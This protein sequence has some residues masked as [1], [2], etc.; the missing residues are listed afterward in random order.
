M[1]GGKRYGQG[2]Y[3]AVY[4]DPRIPCKNEEYIRDKIGEKHEVSKVMFDKNQIKQLKNT[5]NI[6]N[7]RFKDRTEL[8]KYI[9]IPSR[10]C[11]VNHAELKRNPEV[12]TAKWREYDDISKYKLQTVS[13]KGNHDLTEEIKHIKT[14]EQFNNFMTG[15]TNVIKGLRLLHDNNIM[16]GDLKLSNIITVNSTDFRII[17]TDELR[18]FDQIDKI[19]RTFF[20][21]NFLYFIWPLATVFTVSKNSTPSHKTISETISSFANTPYN[22]SNINYTKTAFSSLYSSINNVRPNFEKTM[23]AEKDPNNNDAIKRIIEQSST[24]TLYPYIDRYSF[25]I[26]LMNAL[27]LYLTLPKTSAKDLIV[28]RMLDIIEKCCFIDYGFKT[29]TAEIE[30]DYLTLVYSIHRRESPPKKPVAIKECP[31]GKMINP[32]TGRCIK[33]K[34][35]K[36]CP[37]G[38]VLNPITRR[39]NKDKSNKTCPPGKVLNQKTRRCIKIKPEKTCPPGKVLN[40]KTRRCNKIKN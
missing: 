16:H 31:P 19:D 38:K 34:P 10:I 29:T 17:D 30:N 35:E 27:K 1:L 32:N 36:I 20:Y 33:V 40:L 21:E 3:G 6:V 37:P 12:Y 4:G 24:T 11:D 22:I 7:K 23:L 25:G 8:D 18:P 39:C 15:L 28:T 13:A 2:T 9:I 14:I 26:I 5:I